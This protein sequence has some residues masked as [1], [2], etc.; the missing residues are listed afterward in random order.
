MNSYYFGKTMKNARDRT[1]LEIILL[2]GY[3]R[4]IKRQLKLS[5]KGIVNH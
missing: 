2:S 5:F 1:N 3:D 4:T